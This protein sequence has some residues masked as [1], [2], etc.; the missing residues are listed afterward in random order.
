[1]KI[2]TVTFHGAHNY[3]AVLQAY[4]LQKTLLSLGYENEIIDH[5]VDKV[6]MF[7]KIKMEFKRENIA[8]IYK[9]LLTLLRYKDKK[10]MFN[11]FEKFINEDLVLTKPYDSFEELKT[12][13]PKADVY[14][15]GSDQIW[16]ISNRIRDVFFL[17]FG[18]SHIKRMS[19]AASMGIYDL[20]ME[21]KMLF[22]E[23]I[24]NFDRVSVREAEASEF[25]KS[26]YCIESEVH[27][28]PVFLLTKEEWEEIAIEYDTD[29]KY[30][31]CY[32][33][34][35]SKLLND[36]LMKLKQITG[37]DVIVITTNSREKV[38]GDIYIRNAGP[39]DFLGLIKNAEFVLTTSFHGT[40]FS[41]L[42]QKRFF[43]FS[44]LNSTRITNILGL[45]GLNN[46]LIINPDDI[47]I[48]VV[49]YTAVNKKLALERQRSLDYLKRIQEK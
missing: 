3:G 36:S 22:G 31:L 40:A 30:I 38:Y 1:M 34:L 47:S 27:V 5:R 42:F 48:E 17:K 16:N 23:L 39:R 8:R 19:Y 15:A 18:E 49:N 13:P 9:N 7:S 2:K 41:I 24:K 35:Y 45:L 26:N 32:P 46:R 37:Y 20:D 29:R 4:A 25:I 10:T 43:S 33:L 11:K 12:Y 14:L 28:D 6:S 21:K 44:V